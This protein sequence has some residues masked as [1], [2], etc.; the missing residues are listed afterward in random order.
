MKK[1]IY[2]NLL[3]PVLTRAHAARAD[4]IAGENQ[5]FGDIYAR[6]QS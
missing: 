3:P 2:A 4:E 5:R 6:L 1:W